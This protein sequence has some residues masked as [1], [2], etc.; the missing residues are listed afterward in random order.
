KQGLTVYFWSPR[1]KAVELTQAMAKSYTVDIWRGPMERAPG[2]MGGPIVLVASPEAYCRSGVFGG[3]FLA[4][5]N[6]PFPIFERTVIENA[7]LSTMA[8]SYLND[9]D[10][11]GQ[12][13][14]GDFRGDGGWSNL[15][16]QRGHAAWL[17]F[18]RS[19]DP[20][21][22]HVAE[23]AARHYRDSDIDQF[24]G[25]AIIHNVSHTLGTRSTSHAWVQGMLDHCLVTG[26]RRTMEVALLH[27]GQL[28]HT[29]KSPEKRGLGG[30]IVTRI[31]DN[32]ADLFMVTSD[33]ALPNAY[34]TILNELRELVQREKATMPG[35]FQDKMYG[36]WYYRADFMPWYGLYSLA[37]MR[38]ATG[39][40]RWQEAFIAEANHALSRDTFAH[41]SAEFFVRNELSDDERIVRCLAEGS[42]GDRGCMLFP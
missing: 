1:V 40:P 2:G 12:F 6:S 8:P 33:D 23:A 15:E 38:L 24:S 32:L 37:K 5:A 36:P 10:C 26:D 28:K 34:G 22:F 29:L 3:T 41:S 16:T 19:G 35:I 20:A 39:D 21:L 42:I 31:L 18:M 4:T 27:A 9:Y 7:C 11:Y 13:N 25:A 17:Y 30:R 14:Q